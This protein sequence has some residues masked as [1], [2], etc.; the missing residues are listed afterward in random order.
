MPMPTKSV[1]AHLYKEH[2]RVHW[3]TAYNHSTLWDG[4]YLARPVSRGAGAFVRGA[5]GVS[6]GAGTFVRGAYARNT[7]RRQPPTAGDSRRQPATAGDIGTQKRRIEQPRERASL[8]SNPLVL[9]D[10]REFL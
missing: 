1:Q 10:V 4:L 5:Y 8:S 7:L 2:T 9:T 3:Y 6:G